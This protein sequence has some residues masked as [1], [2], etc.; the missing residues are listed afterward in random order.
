MKEELKFEWSKRKDRLNRRDHKISFET[1]KRVFFDPMCIE[2]YDLKH[3]SIEDRWNVF[4]LIG[5]TVY[6]VTYTNK[7]GT[8][9]IISAR[10]A[11]NYEEE[12]YFYGYDKN[13]Y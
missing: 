1:V 10:R 4:G 5:Q 9:R 8:I 6:R 13:K 11:E 2:Y 12:E 7:N 3:S